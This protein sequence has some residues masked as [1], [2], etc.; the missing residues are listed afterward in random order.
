MTTPNNATIPATIDTDT[1]IDVAPAAPAVTVTPPP[2]PTVTVSAAPSANGNGPRRTALP[3]TAVVD[4]TTYDL[5]RR[6]GASVLTGFSP[7]RPLFNG[8]RVAELRAEL[9]AAGD[10]T[11]PLFVHIAHTA[12]GRAT[13][14]SEYRP[15]INFDR[16]PDGDFPLYVQTTHTARPAYIRV[17]DPANGNGTAR[18][19]ILRHYESAMIL[20]FVVA[21][22][23]APAPAP[24]PIAPTAIPAPAADAPADAGLTTDAVDLI[25]APAPAPTTAD[26]P[27]DPV[28]P[29]ADA[30]AGQ[31]DSVDPAPAP[32]GRARRSR[33]SAD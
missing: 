25:P 26:A 9:A 30:P 20:P 14:A 11:D 13:G 24:A 6:F 29:V 23:R 17:F 19:F 5:T 28:D 31:T 21:E 10:N 3:R 15:L 22:L 7:T 12:A 33:K 32:T 2:L 4:P 1:G 18:E 16:L 8:R 27:V